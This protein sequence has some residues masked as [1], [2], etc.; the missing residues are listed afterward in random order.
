V[1]FE[2]TGE[3][4]LDGE[5]GLSAK[6]RYWL[7]RIRECEESGQTTKAYADAHSLSVTAMYTWRK[8]LVQRGVWPSRAER[9]QRVQLTALAR[10]SCEWRITLPNGV[11]VEFSGLADG[12]EVSAVLSA[13]MGVR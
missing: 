2:L 10:S 1:P 11:Q 12:A 4:M 13:A 3:E 8:R 9:F 6:Q 5:L 7:E